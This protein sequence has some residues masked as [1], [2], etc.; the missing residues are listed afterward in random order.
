[1]KNLQERIAELYRRYD[2]PGHKEELILFVL[3]VVL[4]K[5]LVDHQLLDFSRW[6]AK[7]K[8]S[9]TVDRIMACWAGGEKPDDHWHAEGKVRLGEEIWADVEA[10]V[11]DPELSLADT[12]ASLFEE[13]YTAC[14]QRAHQKREG[15]FYTPAVIADYMA[16]QLPALGAGEKVIDLACGSGALL[17]SVYHR[18]ISN[19]SPEEE[20]ERH[21][22]LLT[23]CLYGVDTD[24]LAALVTRL[25]LALQRGDYCFPRH[26]YGGDGLDKEMFAGEKFAAVIGNPPYLGHKAVDSAAVLALRRD[27]AG[28]YADKSDLAYCF[29]QRGL[30]LLVPGGTLVFLTARYYYEAYF[31]K[32]L[33]TYLQTHSS[34]EKIIDFGGL[35]IID[36][37]GVDPAITVL[38]AGAPQ[39]D[40]QIIVSRFTKAVG[41]L[42]GA[43]TY[44]EDLRTGDETYYQSFTIAQRDLRA[45]LWRFYDPAAEGI[46][47]KLEG[48][49]P[50]TLGDIAETFQGVIT[51]CDK[52]FVI[53]EEERRKYPQELCHP[54][55]KNK[56]VRAFGVAAPSAWL[57][58]TTGVRQIE[59]YPQ[60]E[61]R[62][63]GYAAKLYNRREVKNGKVPWYAPQW[64]RDRRLFT[65]K[66]IIYPY[67]AAINRFAVDEDGVFFSADV[68]GL[69][70]KNSLLGGYRE[71]VLTI[72][73]NTRLYTYYFQSFAKKLGYRLY[74]YYPNTLKKLKIPDLP[75]EISERLG[76]LY[77]KILSQSTNDEKAVLDTLWAADVELMNYFGLSP[78][79]QQIIADY[80]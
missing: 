65:A 47:A 9:F 75:T 73:L 14:L 21:R 8:G 46:I 50:F 7:L 4:T 29:F 17:L 42:H 13:V 58:Y 22:E 34:I 60:V 76:E 63:A 66:K 18:V 62:L 48:H 64:G 5:Y 11:E 6:Q 44:L 19:C 36:G 51:G 79:E 20:S 35:R 24:P 26:I 33:R 55:I 80:K 2:Y 40:Q 61:A 31:A 69:V 41:R 68:Y 78:Q 72:L 28:V 10:F 45:D 39:A 15:I 71:E 12:G 30:E 59:A 70:L 56:D 3:K 57:L 27:Y 49:C 43:E 54:W 67:K 1:M 32:H 77:D 53:S 52:A 25:T 23:A 37:I 38:S 74:E 16:E